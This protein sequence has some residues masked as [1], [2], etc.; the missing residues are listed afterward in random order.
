MRFAV[1]FDA[2]SNLGSAVHSAAR[3]RNQGADKT[4]NR[5]AKQPTRK[6]Q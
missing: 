3:W 5:A 6:A 2:S 1:R 4:S